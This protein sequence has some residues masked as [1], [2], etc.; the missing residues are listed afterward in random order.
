MTGTREP[1]RPLRA[2]IVGAGLMGRWHADAV[3]RCGHLVA[4]IVDT[5]RARATALAR[6]AR[7]A[8]VCT[9]LELPC[10]PVD[11]IHLCTPLE[12]HGPLVQ[13]ALQL[14]CH[15]IV[16][17][18]LASSAAETEQL[19]RL[20]GDH[21]RLLVPVHQFLFQRGVCQATEWLPSIGPLLH[22]ES[23]VCTA[24]AD[25]GTAVDRDHVVSDVLSHPLS[26]IARLVSPNIADAGW[27]VRRPRPGELRADGIVGATTVS[28]LVSAGGRPTMN[29]VR[30]IG[31]AG[32]IHLDLFHGFAVRLR[33]RATR[34]G[35]IA[36]PF[37]SGGAVVIGAALNLGRR[38]ATREPAYPGLR[39]LVRRVYDA[40]AGGGASP[41]SPEETLAVART[42]DEIVGHVVHA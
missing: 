34:S 37:L 14:G 22:F 29:A 24:G 26:L 19:L 3:A 15:V 10:A 8:D 30:L 40:V 23:D 21:D 12:S 6:H 36:Q 38:V 20:A 32:T 9:S 17:K 1:R 31:A 16:E 41:I 11:V 13:T 33:G 4:V 25:R 28:I 42:R 18:P 2:A 35:K 39:E 7:R 5:D 27:H